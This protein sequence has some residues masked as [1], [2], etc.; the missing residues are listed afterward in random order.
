[1]VLNPKITT[2]THQNANTPVTFF[3]TEVTFW[4]KLG[5]LCSVLLVISSLSTIHA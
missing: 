1:M 5:N 3:N 2:S 4:K